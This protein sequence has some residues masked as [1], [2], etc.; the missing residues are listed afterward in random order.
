MIPIRLS[1]SPAHVDLPWPARDL[2]PN[3]RVHWAVRAKAAKA[4][5]LNAAWSAKAAGFGRMEAEAIQATVIF[6]P[7]D[8]RNR[9]EDGMLTSCKA[10]LDGIADVI[11]VDDSKWRLSI[12]RETPRQPGGVRVELASASVEAA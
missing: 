5:R 12:R 2:H 1:K 4:A 8:N 7:P 6:T 9:D 10:Y 3:A 11:G